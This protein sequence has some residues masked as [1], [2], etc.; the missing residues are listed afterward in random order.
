MAKLI[1]D[2]YILSPDKAG[3]VGTCFVKNIVEIRHH[4][5]LEKLAG[6]CKEHIY[7]S[8]VVDIQEGEDSTYME[9]LYEKVSEIVDGYKRNGLVSA[10][11]MLTI[12][13]AYTKQLEQYIL[14]LTSAEEA[15]KQAVVLQFIKGEKDGEES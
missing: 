3:E 12:A 14:D 8:V 4:S 10:N 5:D 6:Y 1:V 7:F 13:H 2:I 11:G 9:F 15:P